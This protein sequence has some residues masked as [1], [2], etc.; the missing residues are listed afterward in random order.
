[1]PPMRH[2]PVIVLRDVWTI[3][4]V[5]AAGTRGTI[6]HV[7]PPGDLCEVALTH[8]SLVVTLPLGLLVAAI[9]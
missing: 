3:H 4:G 8:S 1:M 7:F 9:Y 6:V 5:I 2:D